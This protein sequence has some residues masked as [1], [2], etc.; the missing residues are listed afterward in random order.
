MLRGGDGPG[1][2]RE[3]GDGRDGGGGWGAM[4]VVKEGCS[5]M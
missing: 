3:G 5:R 1:G 2:E 4:V